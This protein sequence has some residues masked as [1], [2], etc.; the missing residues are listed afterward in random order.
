MTPP[1]SPQ[2]IHSNNNSGQSSCSDS[3]SSATS[4]DT[5][6]WTKR[7]KRPRMR[8]YA[9]DEQARVERRKAQNQRSQQPAKSGRQL[10]SQEDPP[11]AR[12]KSVLTR[13]KEDLRNRIGSDTSRSRFQQNSGSASVWNRLDHR[14]LRELNSETDSETVAEDEAEWALEDEDY[15][16]LRD[17]LGKKN[18]EGGDL[19]TKLNM[20]K[21]LR[22]KSPL[23][24]EIDN[25]EYYRLIDSDN[26]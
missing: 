7:N 18:I 25:D 23:Q 19:R 5:V 11:P 16:D 13:K 15:T 9:D 3:D 2:I 20:K 12:G 1:P 24:I 4:D 17:S 10:R 14:H 26:E 22:Q 8:M 21:T 6:P